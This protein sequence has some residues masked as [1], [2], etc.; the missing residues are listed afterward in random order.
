MNAYSRAKG[1]WVHA[2]VL[3]HRYSH[4]LQTVQPRRD[5]ILASKSHQGSSCGKQNEL[6]HDRST[7]VTIYSLDCQIDPSPGL[8]VAAAD[9]L[10]LT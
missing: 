2:A 5:L 8:G 10:K 9:R 3:W 6:V 7:V 4:L 1:R